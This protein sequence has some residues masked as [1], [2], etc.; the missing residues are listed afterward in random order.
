[1]QPTEIISS[2]ANKVGFDLIGFSKVE[3]LSAENERLQKW[4]SNNYHAGMEYMKRNIDKREDITKIFPQ[5]KSV[6]SLGLIYF[7]DKT[8]SNN[9]NN[10]KISRYAWGR[11]YHY[12]MWEMVDE[13]SELIKKEIPDFESKSYADTGPVMDKVWAVKSGLGWMGKNSNIINK[14]NGSYFFI[15]NIFNNLELNSSDIIND[16]C[17]TCNAC[18]KAC[19]TQAIVSDFVIDANKCISYLTI[20][21]KNGISDEFIGKFNNWIFGCDICQEVCP[22]NI[23]FAYKTRIKDF[24]NNEKIELN[25]DEV[26]SMSQSDFKSKFFDS[27]VSRAKLKGLQRN[28][29]HLKKSM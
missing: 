6:I 12:V 26:I 1:M 24:I 25:L 19:P 2:L 10:G 17:G 28:A 13:L 27:P 8:Y 9:K 14:K 5:A 3:L 7:N 18:I 20:E 16:F 21:N 29:E 11:D 22:W 23:K 4:L 15:A